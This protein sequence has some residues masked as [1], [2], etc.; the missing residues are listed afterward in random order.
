MSGHSKWANIKHRK[1]R[2]D[3]RRAKLWSKCA[4]AIIVAA[5]NG[6]GDPDSNITLRYT[7]EEARGHNIPKDTIVNAIKKGTGELADASVY[8]EIRYEGYGPNGVA[9]LLDI[10]TDNRNRTSPEIKKIFER[11][12]GNL[13]TTGCVSFMFQSRG[14]IFVA[15]DAAD[16]DT[17]T[18]AVL[19]AGAEDVI[20]AGESW[21]ILCQSGDLIAVRDAVEAAGLSAESFGL[22]MIPTSSVTCTGDAAEKV[23]KLM[24]ELED[25]EDVQKAYA[26][27]DIPDEEMARLSE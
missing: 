21:Q 23:L 24:E 14:E 18:M 22:T 25:N 15:K 27:F 6:G 20:D 1:G 9:V 19:E 10:L 16:E 5:K 8:E 13:G 26:N 4:R 11:H 7:I 2:Q 3:A 17:I 12:S